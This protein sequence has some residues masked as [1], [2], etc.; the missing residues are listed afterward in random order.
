[1]SLA[2][3]ITARISVSIGVAVAPAQALDRVAL[4]RLADE[5]LY[6]AKDQGRNRVM[7]VGRSPGEGPTVN[8]ARASARP[9]RSRTDSAEA[10]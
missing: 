2:P 3:G 4:L 8:V 5:A 1:M 9:R 7:Y 10:S 6:L